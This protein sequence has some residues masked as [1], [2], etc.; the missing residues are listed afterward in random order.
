MANMN[1]Q[2]LQ[3]VATSTMGLES[4]V[5]RELKALGYDPHNWDSSPGRTSFAGSLTDIARA[6]IYLRTAGKVLLE[7]A[8]FHV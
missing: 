4:V 8:R 7:L 3:L 5:A 6:N 2:A 1:E